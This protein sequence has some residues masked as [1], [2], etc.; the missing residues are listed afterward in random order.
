MIQGEIVLLRGV[1]IGTLHKWLGSTINNR[2]N[3]TIV[4]ENKIDRDH[5][6]LEEKTML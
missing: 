5:T 3:N 6:L 1:W 4:P 2:C